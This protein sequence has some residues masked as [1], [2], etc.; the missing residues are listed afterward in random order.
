MLEAIIA[1]G[2]IVTAISSALTLVA[3]SVKASKESETSIVAGNLAREGVEVVRA[4]R[5]SN[6]LGGR[7]FD[8]GM[9]SGTDV[10]GIP[11]FNMASGLW[12]INFAAADSNTAAAARV[13]RHDGTAAGST[14][15]LLVQADPQP[16][17]TMGTQFYRTVTMDLL[18]DN[19]TGGFNTAV[20]GA[21]CG[22]AAKVG[23]NVA[24]RV[25]WVLGGKVRNLVVEERLFDWR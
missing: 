22:T 16:T 6:W 8:A 17:G 20:A 7:E 12:T 10:T 19:G 15:G 3:G 9:R 24:S 23:V 21:D 5:D 4:I 18:C 13:W 14:L 1:C 25:R 11:V 2:I